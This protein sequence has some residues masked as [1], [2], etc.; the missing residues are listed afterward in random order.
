MERGKNNFRICSYRRQTVG[1][2]LPTVWRPQL[3]SKHRS[4]FSRVPMLKS[5]PHVTLPSET[6]AKVVG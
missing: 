6:D 1:G 2:Q 4:C 5:I 3:Q